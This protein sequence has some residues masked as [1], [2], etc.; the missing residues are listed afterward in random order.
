[1]EQK[2]EKQ[3]HFDS[4][5]NINLSHIQ[6]LI[7]YRTVKSLLLGYKSQSVNTVYRENVCLVRGLYKTHKHV[8]V[9]RK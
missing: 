3:K 9:G 7:S 1:M 8:H 2:F 6:K 4:K 5:T